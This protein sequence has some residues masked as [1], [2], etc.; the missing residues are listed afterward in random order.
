MMKHAIYGLFVAVFVVF[1]WQGIQGWSRQRE[2]G[3]QG[4]RLGNSLDEVPLQVGTFNPE[5]AHKI[6]MQGH[7]W[8]RFESAIVNMKRD[9]PPD[10]A[11]PTA[12]DQRKDNERPLPDLPLPLPEGRMTWPQIVER[13]RT[14]LAPVGIK[15]MT[16]EPSPPSSFYIDVPQNDWVANSTFLYLRDASQKMIVYTVTSDGVAI[17]TDAAVDRLAVDAKL[18]EM[19]RRVAKEHMDPRLDAEFAPDLVDASVVA[20]SRVVEGQTG[21]EIVADPS[22]W[23]TMPAIKWRGGPRRLRDALDEVTRRMRCFW[24]YQDGRVFILKPSYP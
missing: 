4:S 17:G 10:P 24:R 2:E 14:G 13:L 1:A 6:G 5:A 18:V 23:E 11:V 9:L 8:Q 7:P 19:R 15:V 21:V 12:E 3:G 20:F 22:L 16:G